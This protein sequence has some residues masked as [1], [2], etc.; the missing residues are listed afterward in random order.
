M[1]RATSCSVYDV[2]Y[3]LYKCDNVTTLNSCFASAKNIKW[4]LLDS[5]RRTMFNHCTR[6]VNMDSIFWGIQSQDF[7]ILTSTYKY[8]STEHNGLFSPLVSLQ[9][10]SSAFYSGGTKYTDP[11]FLAKFKGNVS[12]KSVSYT[13]LT[14][15]TNSRV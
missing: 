3:F 6:V 8:G 14:L 12:S 1:L 11:T 13:H 2:Y 9:S 5:P 4:D 10:M 15:P 7:R